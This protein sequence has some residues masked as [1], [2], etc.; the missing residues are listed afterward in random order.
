[1]IN[2]IVMGWKDLKHKKVMSLFLFVKITVLLVLIQALL[3]NVY[4]IQLMDSEINKLSFDGNIYRLIDVTSD[5]RIHQIFHSSE[6]VTPVFSGIFDYI[7]NHKDMEVFPIFS[8]VVFFDDYNAERISF[9]DSIFVPTVYSTT[10][11]EEVFTLDVYSGR[12]FD[13]FDFNNDLEV[14]PAIMGYKYQSYFDVGDIFFDAIGLKYEVVGFLQPGL[15]YIDIM[16]SGNLQKLDEMIMLPM[17]RT[18]FFDSLDYINILSR[19]HVIPYNQ[20]ILHDIIRFSNESGGLDYIFQNINE[21]W[22]SLMEE[23]Q[24]LIELQLWIIIL[25]SLFSLTSFTI[26][27]MQSINKQL[28]EFG[29]NYLVGATHKDIIIRI[30]SQILPFL[31]LG[32]LFRMIIMG[33]SRFS[34]HVFLFSVL[35]GIV[36]SILPFIKASRLTLDSMMRWKER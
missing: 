36:A 23:H 1:M 26:S 32:N 6:E 18:L 8:S 11:F 9:L 3:H 30:S 25:I 24:L 28:Q 5:D 20:E 33:D 7:L 22:S 31:I 13:Y 14:I 17:N 35:F 27:M 12:S 10:T 34:N 15:F 4:D 16:R 19:L 2:Q 21:Q 29:I